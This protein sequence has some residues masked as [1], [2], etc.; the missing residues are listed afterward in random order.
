MEELR[1]DILGGEGASD[2]F[3][4]MRAWRFAQGRNF[5]PQKCRQLGIHAG[6]RARSGR[7]A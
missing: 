4:L 5:D 3:T 2:F 6:R 1:E 7:C